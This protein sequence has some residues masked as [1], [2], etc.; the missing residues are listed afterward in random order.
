MT[1][2][3]HPTFRGKTHVQGFSVD[4]HSHFQDCQACQATF[5]TKH[6]TIAFNFSEL[7]M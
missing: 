7:V 5:D 3:C 4:F 1:G 6:L 2:M